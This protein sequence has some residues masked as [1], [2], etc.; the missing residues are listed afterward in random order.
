MVI[1]MF[2]RTNHLE[3][4]AIL[5]ICRAN[6]WEYN[7]FS[8]KVWENIMIATVTS[9][10]PEGPFKNPGRSSK[11][12]FECLETSGA[13]RSPEELRR[14]QRRSPRVPVSTRGPLVHRHGLVLRALL[15]RPWRPVSREANR[16]RTEDSSGHQENPGNGDGCQGPRVPDNRVRRLRG[17]SGRLILSS[18]L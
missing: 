10:V 15:E 2:C 6:H 11:P 1:L 8:K 17:W 13:L 14:S 5:A 3:N 9:T 16:A 4:T 18:S 12:S 7:Y